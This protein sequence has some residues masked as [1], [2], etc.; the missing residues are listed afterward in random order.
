MTL[1]DAVARAIAERTR[2]YNLPGSELDVRNTPND[3]VAI[4]THYAGENVRRGG[5]IPNEDDFSDGLIK[6]VAVIFA[7]LE[8]MP[9]MIAAGSLSP[10]KADVVEGDE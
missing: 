2:Q 6:A 9:R 10:G 7:A 8:H 3:W 5:N 4:A 1:D